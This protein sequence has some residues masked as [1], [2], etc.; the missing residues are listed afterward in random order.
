MDNAQ[1]V[2]NPITLRGTG[3]RHLLTSPK[4]KFDFAVV[5]KEAGRRKLRVKSITRSQCQ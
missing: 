3:V 4:S 2:K 1:K 5:S